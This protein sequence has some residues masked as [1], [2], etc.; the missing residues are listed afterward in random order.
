M[1]AVYS[2]WL[3][4]FDRALPCHVMPHVSRFPHRS[5][6]HVAEHRF[7]CA[8]GYHQSD[9]RGDSRGDGLDYYVVLPGVPSIQ[10]RDTRRW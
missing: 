8:V 10:A 9:L 4:S 2:Q 6:V 3:I 5:C 7:A 1:S